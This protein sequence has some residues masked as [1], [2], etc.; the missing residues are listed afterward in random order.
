[1]LKCCG[2]YVNATASF[3]VN[4]KE[5]GFT[6]TPFYFNT[7]KTTT[8]WEA[9]N[10]PGLSG[11]VVIIGNAVS[12]TTRVAINGTHTT[13]LLNHE[14]YAISSDPLNSIIITYTT[15]TDSLT[16]IMVSLSASRFEY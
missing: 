16:S 3:N 15:S 6:S 11:T 8:S 1:M 10:L 5:Y 9:I 7:S 2:G 14:T 13:Q 12:G 4:S